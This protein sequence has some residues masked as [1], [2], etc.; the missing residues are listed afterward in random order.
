M[1]QVKGQFIVISPR[2]WVWLW[3]CGKLV[4]DADAAAAA[5]LLLVSSQAGQP[6]TLR[7]WTWQE[8]GGW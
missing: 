4:A 8:E 2:R 1:R 3:L 7:T 6:L 5:A